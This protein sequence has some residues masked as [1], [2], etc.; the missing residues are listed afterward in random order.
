MNDAWHGIVLKKTRG[1]LDGSNLY[2]RLKIR[3]P[4]GSIRKVTVSR[5]FWNAVKEGDMV[6]KASGQEPSRE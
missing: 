4:D 2:R 1:L 3:Q 5:T 6:T